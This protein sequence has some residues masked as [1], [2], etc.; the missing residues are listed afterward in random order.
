MVLAVLR[1]PA[2]DE[3]P[4]KGA[5]SLSNPLAV[6]MGNYGK[7]QSWTFPVLGTGVVDFP[8][9]LRVLDEHHFAGPVTI[10]V[11]GFQGVKLDEAQTKQYVGQSA[12]FIKSLGKFR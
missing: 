3:E 1:G 6:R 8:A 10:E 11:E 5:T 4:A 7:F 2:A 9:V 12:A